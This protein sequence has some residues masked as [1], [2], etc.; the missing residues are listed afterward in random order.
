MFTVKS[1]ALSNFEAYFR[2]RRVLDADPLDTSNITMFGLQIY[3]G[4]YL[5]IKQKGL[6]SL[7]IDTIVAKRNTAASSS[8]TPALDGGLKELTLIEQ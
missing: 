3:G 1:L 5:P 7:E 6:G 8:S 2:G 4:V